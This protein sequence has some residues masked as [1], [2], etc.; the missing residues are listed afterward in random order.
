ME[1][2]ISQR[3]GNVLVT[4]IR[5]DGEF[6]A[7]SSDL[8]KDSA[9][10]VIQDGAEYVL[11][12]MSGVPFISSSGIRVI[13][14]L[15]NQLHPH[16]SGE[17]GKAV[18]REMREGTYTASRLKILNPTNQVMN[19]LR[20]IGIDSYIEIYESED[21]AMAAFTESGSN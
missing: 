9:H 10:D 14:S 6:D 4:I 19:V 11:L 2:D 7:A 21:D 16:K 17:A 18:A 20:M 8:V 1:I 3:Q 5:L 13:Y 12:D 15:Y